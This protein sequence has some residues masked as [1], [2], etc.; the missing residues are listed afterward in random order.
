MMIIV[1]G[2]A[3]PDPSVRQPKHTPN[4]FYDLRIAIAD[5][6]GW[7][8]FHQRHGNYYMYD[9]HKNK[10]LKL[11]REYDALCLYQKGSDP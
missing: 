8:E 6:G 3:H 5:N 11:Q 1:G 4:P 2:V 9:Y 10:R 7:E